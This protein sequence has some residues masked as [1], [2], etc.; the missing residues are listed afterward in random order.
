MNAPDFVRAIHG[1]AN[2]GDPV[3]DNLKSIFA[4]FDEPTRAGI[5]A[6]LL[7]DYPAQANQLGITPTTTDTTT[8]PLVETVR[9][10]PVAGDKVT[11]DGQAGVITTV[12]DGVATVITLDDGKEVTDVDYLYV[13]ADKALADSNW[14]AAKK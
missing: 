14:Q 8:A 10:I 2:T 11:V 6:T 5:G 3:S 1:I 7:Q 12:E 13:D 4:A 9:P